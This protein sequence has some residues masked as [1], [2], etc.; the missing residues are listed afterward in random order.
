VI[1]KAVERI[2][3]GTGADCTRTAPW[4]ATGIRKMAAN[5]VR[6]E[7]KKTNPGNQV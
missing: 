5:N 3:S 2:S 7:S 1:V 4:T 6:R